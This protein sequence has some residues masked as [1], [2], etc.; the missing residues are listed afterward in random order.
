MPGCNPEWFDSLSAWHDGEVTPEDRRRVEQHLS[1]C[2]ACRRASALLGELRSAVVRTAD[3]DVPDRVRERSR[4]TLYRRAHLRRSWLA[5]GASAA[6][7]AAAAAVLIMVRPSSNLAPSNLS[8][9]L[10]DELVGHHLS[11]FTREQPCDFES[12]DPTA[13]AS[14][15]EDHV[16]Y[17][18]DVPLPEGAQLIGARLCR[19]TQARTAA[20]MYRLETGSLETSPLTVFVPPRNSP[21]AEMARSFAGDELRCTSGMLGS[22]ICI[23]NGQ[24]PMLAVAD[25]Q[26]SLLARALAPSP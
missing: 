22:S 11:G 19:L 4:S 17:P 16:G 9:S 15:L 7:I 10:R 3:H 13:V 20:V 25:T 26:A 14:W 2:A 23:R 21:A 12:S 18:V 24:Q 6:V 5:A 8:A 1:D